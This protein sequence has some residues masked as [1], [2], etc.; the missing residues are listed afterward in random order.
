M[1][2]LFKRK[3]DVFEPL[4]FLGALGAGGLSISFFMYLMFLTKHPN[5]PVP[6]VESV[7]MTFQGG[8][9]WIQGTIV[10]AYAGLILFGIAHLALLYKN[11]RAYFTYRKT[12]AYTKLFSSNAEVQLMAIPLSFGM[13]MNVLFA[14]AATMIPGL[15]SI[16]EY[17]F[18]FAIAGFIIIGLVTIGMLVRYLGR[19]FHTGNFNM[20][21][22]NNF[23]QLLAAFALAMTGV[24]LSGPAAMTHHQATASIA[25]IASIVFFSIATLLFITKFIIG[26]KAALEKGFSLENSPSIWIIIPYLTLLG[27]ALIRYEHAF[28]TVVGTTVDKTSFFTITIIF[29]SIQ[30]F[31][32]ILGYALMKTNGYFKKFATPEN[33]SIG[34]FALICPGVAGVV[35][36]F[37]LLH[38]GLVDN[39]VVSMYSVMY[40]VILTLLITFQFKTIFVYG[41]LAKWVSI[42]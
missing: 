1:F 29:A 40:F 30:A 42:K 6:T 17:I 8:N 35:L 13:T 22:N 33:T 36:G 19:L 26:Y 18:P 16:I 24:G 34:S 10:I 2:G 41:K 25:L 7:L 23:S 14:F 38:R 12:P 27:I 31:F 20:D 28:H 32:G 5:T 21:V 15:W 39:G 9:I 37:F 3:H 11:I 4:S